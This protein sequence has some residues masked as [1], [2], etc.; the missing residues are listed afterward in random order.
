MM[1]KTGY[2]VFDTLSIHLIVI[3]AAILFLLLK[4]IQN[5]HK[6]FDLVYNKLNPYLIT[7]LYRLL[8]LEQSLSLIIFFTYGNISNEYGI[9][10]LIFVIIDILIIGFTLFWKIRTEHDSKQYAL[11]YFN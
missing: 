6:G 11:F 5:L 2:Y 4:K 10:S 3:F 7:Y 1:K 9:I 8:I